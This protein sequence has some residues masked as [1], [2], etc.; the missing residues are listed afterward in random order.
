VRHCRLFGISSFERQKGWGRSFLPVRARA[1][2]HI[3]LL[4]RSVV[5]D[6]HTTTLSCSLGAAS[7]A[8]VT[9]ES[10]PD[11]TLFR[12]L[13]VFS[14]WLRRGLLRSS[15]MASTGYIKL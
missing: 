7:H 9:F 14:V 6:G 15:R 12:L 3:R 10:T 5:V 8:S 11:S 13:G 4:S 1:L 2:P